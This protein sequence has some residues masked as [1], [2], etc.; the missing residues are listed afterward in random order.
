MPEHTFESR[1]CP[2]CDGKGCW[3]CANT[4][5]AP[6]HT[7]L[8]P[9]HKRPGQQPVCTRVLLSD[10]GNGY[11]AT[12]CSTCGAVLGPH[13]QPPHTLAECVRSLATR[14]EASHA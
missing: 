7:T 6:A 8:D 12:E 9:D 5:R 1:E 2:A 11:D 14:L 3:A 10:D 4:G 13:P